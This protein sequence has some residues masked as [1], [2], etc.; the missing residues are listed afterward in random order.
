M[1]YLFNLIKHY[2][3]IFN[4]FVAFIGI[5]MAYANEIVL[6]IANDYNKSL[7]NITNKSSN[8]QDI[9]PLVKIGTIIVVGVIVIF[10]VFSLV[11]YFLVDPNIENNIQTAKLVKES[12]LISQT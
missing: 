1:K 4:L 9:I 7:Q 2:Y 11:R 5:I 6:G 3:Y 12:V 8:Y 10:G